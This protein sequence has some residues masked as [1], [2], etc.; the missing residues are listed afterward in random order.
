MAYQ[1]I[2]DEKAEGTGYELSLQLSG[3]RRPETGLRKAHP[4]C[5]D[6]AIQGSKDFPK[7]E[8]AVIRIYF[9]SKLVRIAEYQPQTAKKEEIAKISATLLP[10]LTVTIPVFKSPPVVAND[11]IDG[12][13]HFVEWVFNDLRLDRKFRCLVKGLVVVYFYEKKCRGFSLKTYAMAKFRSG[14]VFRPKY[15]SLTLTRESKKVSPRT[16]HWKLGQSTSP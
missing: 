7:V 1:I 15:E 3:E 12:D 14:A 5:W 11:Q 4:Y 16:Q 2:L 10:Q 6:F 13:S 8:Q 9:A